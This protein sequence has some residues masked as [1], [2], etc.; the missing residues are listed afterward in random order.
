LTRDV[1]RLTGSVAVMLLER[2]AVQLRARLG[3][4]AQLAAQ[5][6][7]HIL[8][9]VAS[10][11]AFGAADRARIAGLVRIAGITVLL[12]RCNIVFAV[13]DEAAVDRCHVRAILFMLVY[14]LPVVALPRGSGLSLCRQLR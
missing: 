5:T 10:L 13:I 4:G 6:R 3:F 8:S 11:V 12:A 1:P 2:R 14:G 7:R 9:A